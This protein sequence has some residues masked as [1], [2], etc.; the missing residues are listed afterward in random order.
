MIDS[1]A[2]SD[3]WDRYRRGERNV[4]SRRLYTLQGQQTFEEIRRRYR[5]DTDFRETVDRYVDEFERLLQ[6]VEKEDKT[7]VASKTYLMAE[8]G[9]AASTEPNWHHMTYK[10][11]VLGPPVFISQSPVPLDRRSGPFVGH[12]IEAGIIAL[13]TRMLG[14][15]HFAPDRFIDRR[16]TRVAFG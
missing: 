16:E 1:A 13:P 14:A 12:D 3:L 5:R 6:Q 11:A 9:K 8:T 2:A 10:R 15:R 7:G 4:F